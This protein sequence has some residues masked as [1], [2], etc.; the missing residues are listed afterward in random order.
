MLEAEGVATSIILSASWAMTS[1][2]LVSVEANTICT[3]AG[4]HCKKRSREMWCLWHRLCHLGAV[5][6]VSTTALASCLLN[7]LRGRVVVVGTV[8][9]L[10]S[11][12]LTDASEFYKA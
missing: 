5:A 7:L 12:Q 4:K 1:N 8:Q 3:L 11:D 2:S 9:R 6:Y 10:L